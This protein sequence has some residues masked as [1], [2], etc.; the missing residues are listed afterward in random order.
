MKEILLQQ[1]QFEF[2]ANSALLQ[3]LKQA[4]VLHERALL[5]FS[6]INSVNSIWL[7]RLK[8]E[9]VTTNLFQQRTLPECESLLLENN[10]NWTRF[11]QNISA[12]D[13]D[14]TIEFDFP[15]D[16]TVRVMS[17][18]DAIF[19]ITNHSSYHRGQIITLIKGSVEN[20]PALG[21]VFFASK[22]NRRVT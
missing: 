6:H 19:H 2:W 9:V 15:V 8:G 14:A 10:E 20:L 7:N 1:M 11:L 16:G 13:L 17:K 3:T 18:K 22:A 4:A 21:Y 5:L 12:A